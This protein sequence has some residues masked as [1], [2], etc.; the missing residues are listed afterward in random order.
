MGYST[1]QRRAPELDHDNARGGVLNNDAAVVRCDPELVGRRGRPVGPRAGQ[2]P[3]RQ[4][5]RHVRSLADLPA[6][7]RRM[8]EPGADGCLLGGRPR[9]ARSRSQSTAAPRATRTGSIASYA[10][11]FGDDHG[12]T[13]A[14]ASHTYTSAGTYTITLAVTDDQGATGTTTHQVTVPPAA[15]NQPPTAPSRPHR[16]VRR[17]RCRS[18]S[19]APRRATRTAQSPRTRGTSATAAAQPAQPQATPTRLPAPTRSR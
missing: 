5:Q 13:G 16:R 14:T 10:W 19:T 15:A 4:R 18:R 2:R 11:D 7:H 6:R 12:A 8:H 3:V 1:R 17:A 9:P